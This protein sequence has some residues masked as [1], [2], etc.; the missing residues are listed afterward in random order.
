MD[1]QSELDGLNVKLT[2]ALGTA[3]EL[4]AKLEAAQAVETELNTK[5]K[6]ALSA[7]A[8]LTTQLSSSNLELVES[9]A[10][11][12]VAANSLTE[13]KQGS[14]QQSAALI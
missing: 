10:V 7:E 3:S 13:L 1:K 4:E 5:L 12:T 6:T 11:A 14:S 9:K 2:T 8:E